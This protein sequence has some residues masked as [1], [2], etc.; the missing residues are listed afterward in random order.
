MWNRIANSLS[1]ILHPYLVPTYIAV[2]IL[3]TDSVFCAIPLAFEVLHALGFDAIQP[4]F[5]PHHIW[6]ITIYRAQPSLQVFT[7]QSSLHGP[8][9]QHRLLHTWRNKLHGARVFGCIFRDCNHRSMLLCNHAPMSKVV[10]HKPSHDS[11]RRGYNIP[12]DPKPYR[13]LVT[14]HISTRHDTP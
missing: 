2:I 10:A 11:C 13:A 14:P 6:G 12:H 7:P 1:I 8:N 5:T 3:G 4:Y 9:S